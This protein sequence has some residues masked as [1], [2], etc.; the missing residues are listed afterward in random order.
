MKK[1]RDIMNPK[2]FCFSPDDTVFKVAKIL[3]EKNIS[4][5]PVVESEK[6]IGMVS[7]SDIVRFMR[8]KLKIGSSHDLPS[9]S[10]LVLDIFK[11]GKDYM[12]LKEEIQEASNI[13]I[14][15]IMSKKVVSI[16]PEASIFDAANLIENNDVNR[17]P[18]IESGKLIGIV[19]R[20]D[21][22]RALL[23]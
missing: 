12:D 19:A 16:D 6:V 7:M 18:V 10:L 9:L 2:A 15:N 14:R 21:I 8:T 4:G 1:V 20:A 3:S 11:T 22:I 23:D 13:K 5:A 17:L